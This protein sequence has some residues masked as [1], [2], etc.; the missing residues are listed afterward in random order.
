MKLGFLDL[1]LKSL[2]LFGGFEA[3][4]AADT[5]DLDLGQPDQIIAGNFPAK[6]FAERLQTLVNG[7]Q[8]GLPCLAF[9]DLA[10]DPFFD[11]NLLQRAG[12]PLLG[13]I[14]FA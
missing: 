5:L 4:V 1:V 7:V 11:E 10:I 8:N 9:F 3:I 14:G 6:T 13:Q 12:M 2:E